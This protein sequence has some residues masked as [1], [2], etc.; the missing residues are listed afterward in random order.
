APGLSYCRGRRGRPAAPACRRGSTSR[1]HT[2]RTRPRARCRMTGRS[3]GSAP[4][5][6]RRR[7]SLAVRTGM[8]CLSSVGHYPDGAHGAGDIQRPLATADHPRLIA[9]V[10][11]LNFAQG[12]AGRDPDT[13]S[14]L[15]ADPNAACVAAD[16]R[17]AVIQPASSPDAPGLDREVKRSAEVRDFRAAGQDLSSDRRVDPS[18]RQL[19]GLR[20][21]LQRQVRVDAHPQWHHVAEGNAPALILAPPRIPARASSSPGEVE[22]GHPEWVHLAVDYQGV[23]LAPG[24]VRPLGNSFV[25]AGFAHD[26]AG[27]YGP[28]YAEP[29]SPFTAHG[30][31]RRRRPG[32]VPRPVGCPVTGV[33]GGGGGRRLGFYLL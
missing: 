3:A 2:T 22:A 11:E 18:D 32:G 5:V 14:S 9:V 33:L 13:R 16:P 20:F 27:P 25:H 8:F 15:Q 24:N 7:D 29:G 10:V 12:G 21:D 1:T 30:G 31:R 23:A 4:A 26:V 17:R 19:T 6:P 28:D